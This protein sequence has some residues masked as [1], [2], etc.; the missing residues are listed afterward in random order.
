MKLFQHVP[1][2]RQRRIESYRLRQRIDGRLGV[3]E[4]DMAVAALLVQPAEPGIEGLQLRKDC[5]GLRDA[6][7]GAKIAGFL[8]QG[9]AIAGAGG[10]IHRTAPAG[11]IDS[12]QF[13]SGWSAS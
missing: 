1:A 6:Q 13:G 4:Q 5:Q 7:A 9:V 12:S 3:P 10:G 2:R 11:R 8:K